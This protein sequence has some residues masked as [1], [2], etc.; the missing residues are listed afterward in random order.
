MFLEIN[1]VTQKEIE[2]WLIYVVRIV[3]NTH[4]VFYMYAMTAG[5]CGAIVA[6]R[7]AS[8][9]LELAAQDA[10]RWVIVPLPLGKKPLS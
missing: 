9:S 6:K 3:V 5:K 2:K 1:N 10:I 7:T 4:T 8:A